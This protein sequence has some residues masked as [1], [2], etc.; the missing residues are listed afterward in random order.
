MDRAGQPGA[1]IAVIR[2]NAVASW[3]GCKPPAAPSVGQ[4]G[5]GVQEAVAQPFGLGDGQVTSRAS[6]CG[7]AIRSAT[8]ATAAPHAWLRATRARAA[9]AGRCPWR[10]GSVLMRAWARWRT[11]STAASPLVVCGDQRGVAPTGRELRGLVVAGPAHLRLRLAF[12]ARHRLSMLVWHLR[13]LPRDREDGLWP[14]D[15]DS[16]CELVFGC[17]GGVGGDDGLGGPVPVPLV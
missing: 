9:G 8:I 6:S 3:P 14:G 17:A 7:Q 4:A 11:S 16:G 12:H 13:R 1:G 5:S 15:A 10:G 2:A